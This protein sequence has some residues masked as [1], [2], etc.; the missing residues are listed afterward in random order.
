MGARIKLSN[1]FIKSREID[2]DKSILDIYRER[3]LGGYALKDA[4]MIHHFALCGL[5]GDVLPQVEIKDLHMDVTQRDR[6][7]QINTDDKFT[8][9]ILTTPI[10]SV[11]RMLKIRKIRSRF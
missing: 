7:A 4:G 10:K 11:Y 2:T 3:T 8:E 9:I 5:V 6:M 1:S